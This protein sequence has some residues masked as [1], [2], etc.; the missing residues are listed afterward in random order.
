GRWPLAEVPA[1]ASLPPAARDAPGLPHPAG[2][3]L[4]LLL[5]ALSGTA[6]AEAASR[7]SD[8][9]PGPVR[10]RADPPGPAGP[11]PRMHDGQRPRRGGTLVGV[12]PLLRDTVCPP[13]QHGS[14]A[15]AALGASRGH[16]GTAVDRG[17]NG[18]GGPPQR[19]AT[20]A[21]LPQ[22]AGP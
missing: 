18:G 5:G 8:A 12:G 4:G 2:A 14:A 19:E 21:P 17:G 20:A 3:M 22:G 1:G 16:A 13:G 10:C 9:G 11:T 6:G 7:R 15:V